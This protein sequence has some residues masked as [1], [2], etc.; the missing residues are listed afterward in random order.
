M[1]AGYDQGIH[2]CGCQ[3]TNKP[4]SLTCGFAVTLANQ[5]LCLTVAFMRW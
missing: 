5:F 4:L 3:V 1:R 2:I